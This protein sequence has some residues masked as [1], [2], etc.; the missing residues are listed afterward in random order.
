MWELDHKEGSVPKNRCFRT[1]MLKKTSES[2]LDSEEIKPVNLK[3]N[4]PWILIGR[5]DAEAEAAV[6][7]SSDMNRWLFGK[8]PDAGKDWRQ[9]EKVSEDEI[10]GCHHECSGRELGQTS[11]SGVLQSMALQIVRHDWVTELSHFALQQK[12]AQHHK[13]IILP[14]WQKG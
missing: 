4:Q 14:Q 2:L 13:S 12:L 7:W 3:G 10:A 5:T 9:E 8:V 6:F 11:P 1:V